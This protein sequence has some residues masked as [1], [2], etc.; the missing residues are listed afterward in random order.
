M[1]VAFPIKQRSSG[2]SLIELLVVIAL[3]AALISLAIPAWNSITRHQARN[4]AVSLVMEGLEQARIAASSGKREIWIVFRN[5]PVKKSSFRIIR[6]DAGG[7]SPLGNWIMLPQ[8]VAFLT[9]G[10]TLMEQEPPASVTARAAT[11]SP[12]KT[13]GINF[14]F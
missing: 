7:C 14:C 2:F 4:S 11:C 3:I 1:E 12:L 6:Q 13:G 10:N 8:G 9:G 5:D